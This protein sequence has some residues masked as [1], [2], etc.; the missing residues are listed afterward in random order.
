MNFTEGLPADIYEDLTVNVVVFKKEQSKVIAQLHKERDY[1]LKLQQELAE[2]MDPVI[3]EQRLKIL[4]IRADKYN[5]LNHHLEAAEKLAEY[6]AELVE[7][8]C[9]K[10]VASELMNKQL[11]HQIKN[12]DR[13]FFVPEEIRRFRHLLRRK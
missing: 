8:L 10:L 9:E 1:L 13:D 6:Y 12:P 4:Q 2:T 11:R 5:V 7:F 3:R